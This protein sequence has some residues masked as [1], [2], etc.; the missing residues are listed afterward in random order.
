MIV[1]HWHTPEDAP[2]QW[3]D[4]PSAADLTELLDVAR[5]QV[6]AYAPAGDYTDT[7]HLVTDPAADIPT[8]WRVA[9]LMQARNIWNARLTDPGNGEIG[10]D[11]FVIRPFPLDW[12]IKQMLRPRRGTPVAL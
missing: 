10:D 7:A 4:A 11:T 6:L 2:A 3:S 8:S 9:Q 5:G 1:A 12:T